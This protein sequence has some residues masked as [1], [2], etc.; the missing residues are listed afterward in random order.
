MFP[1][2]MVILMAIASARD[3]G[4][5]LLVRPADVIG[6]YIG[7]LYDSLTRRSYIKGISSTGYQLTFKGRETLVKFLHQNR[8]RVKD[9]IKTLQQLG[10]EISKDIDKLGKKAMEVK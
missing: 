6:E 2:E 9:T 4:K 7:Y 1:S 3:T 10:I 5:E 8:T